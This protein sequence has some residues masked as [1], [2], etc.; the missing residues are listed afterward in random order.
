MAGLAPFVAGKTGTTDD[1]NDAWFVGFSNEV[2]VAVSGPCS[3]R[4]LTF[5]RRVSS[6][7][8]GSST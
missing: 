3:V 5:T 2:T 8:D 7:P 4:C 1:E 6:R